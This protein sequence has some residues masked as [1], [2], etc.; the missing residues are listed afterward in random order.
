MDAGPRRTPDYQTDPARVQQPATASGRRASL[1]GMWL[2]AIP[3]ACCGGP[4]L[5]AALASAGALA[6]G[7]ASVALITVTAGVAV[8]LRHQRRTRCGPEAAG[9]RKGRTR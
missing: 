1:G 4:P 6:W 9:T 8:I 2:I 7:G 5:I 3:F